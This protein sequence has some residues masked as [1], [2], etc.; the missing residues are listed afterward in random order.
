MLSLVTVYNRGKKEKILSYAK[1]NKHTDGCLRCYRTPH[2]AQPGG[3]RQQGANPAAQPRLRGRRATAEAVTGLQGPAGAGAREPPLIFTALQRGELSRS[4][5]VGR[6]WTSRDRLRAGR[7]P[8]PAHP[9]GGGAAGACPA[10][11]PEN[12]KFGLAKS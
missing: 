11:A 5:R 3:T 6:R 1:G 8:P 9:R 2:A 4:Q 12:G 10:P 7:P